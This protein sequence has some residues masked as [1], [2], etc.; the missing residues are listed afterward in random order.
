MKKINFYPGGQ[1][2]RST[3][4]KLL[5]D[6]NFF[7][8]KSILDGITN[9]TAL[10]ILTGLHITLN[11]Q[12]EGRIEVTDGVVYNGVEL[13]NVTGAEGLGNATEVYLR[14][15]EQN[16]SLRPVGGN[17]QYIFTEKYYEVVITNSPLPTDISISDFTRFTAMLQDDYELKLVY[18][19]IIEDGE[20]NIYSNELGDVLITATYKQ[21]SSV[22]TYQ[23]PERVI[24]NH[25]VSGFYVS[26]NAVKPLKIDT[27]G[28]ATLYD[29]QIND[30]INIYLKYNM[31]LPK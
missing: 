14:P 2:F 20:I 12:Y 19:D 5:Q 17:N 26:T 18:E 27:H 4:F 28:I 3:D 21:Q 13:C 29:V 23:L 16:S 10:L 22:N 7:A 8:T 24:P 15:K 6:N 11:E 1:P 9:H 31:N 25:I 30:R